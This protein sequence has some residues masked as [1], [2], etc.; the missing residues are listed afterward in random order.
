MWNDCVSYVFAAVCV[1]LATAAAGCAGHQPDG[2]SA[3]IQG[4]VTPEPSTRPSEEGSVARDTTRVAVRYQVKDLERAVAFYTGQLGFPL[5]QRAGSAFAMV[6]VGE[7]DL[8]L[9]GPKSS[10]SRPMPD[11]RRQEPGGW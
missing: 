5:R 4:G 8:W 2:A 1:M 7:V 10:G 3:S 9:S 11:G 6:R